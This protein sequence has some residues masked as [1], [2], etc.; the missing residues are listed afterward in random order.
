MT[1]AELLLRLHDLDLLALELGDPAF[2]SKLRRLG[3]VVAG[4]EAL[5][6]RRAALV[7]RLEARWRQNYERALRRY[8]AGVAAVRGRVCQGCFMTLPRSATAV[9]VDGISTCEACGRILYWDT[10]VI[11]DSE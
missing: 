2:A 11:A 10:R 1:S 8:G 6:P 9:L 7:S 5:T 3:L 4:P